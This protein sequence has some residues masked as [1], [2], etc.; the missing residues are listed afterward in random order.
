VDSEEG[1]QEVEKHPGDDESI[2]EIPPPPPPPRASSLQPP[3]PPPPP[4]NAKRR[5]AT[6]DSAKRTALHHKLRAYEANRRVTHSTKLSSSS[7]YWK[8]FRALIHSSLEETKRSEGMIKAH[9]IADANYA[10]H[11][12]AIFFNFLNDDGAPLLDHKKRLQQQQQQKKDRTEAGAPSSPFSAKNPVSSSGTLLLGTMVDSHLVI[13]DRFEETSNGIKQDILQHLTPL[14]EKFEQEVKTHEA[15]GNAILEDLEFADH[16]VVEAWG[17][18]VQQQERV[19]NV[20]WCLVSSFLHD[21]TSF[22]SLCI[23]NRILLHNCCEVLIL[24]N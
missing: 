6:M 4:P 22:F 24:W 16:A 7:L 18:S 20:L 3:P 21:I 19:K 5:V 11:M 10:Q 23:R 15:L 17:K 1:T 13:A 8:S 14:R 2:T 12:K 9:V